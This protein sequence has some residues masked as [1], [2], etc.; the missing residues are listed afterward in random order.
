MNQFVTGLKNKN[1]EV[2]CKA[3]RD[4]YHYVRRKLYI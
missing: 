2:R 1:E 4:L 3:A